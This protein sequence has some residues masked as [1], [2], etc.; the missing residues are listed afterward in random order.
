MLRAGKR[1]PGATS[2]VTGPPRSR[3]SRRLRGIGPKGLGGRVALVAGGAVQRGPRPDHPNSSGPVASGSCRR[4]RTIAGRSLAQASMSC[5][6]NIAA[7]QAARCAALVVQS[8]VC[9]IH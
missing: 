6:S 5:R 2:A 4:R 7:A 1:A 8:Y 9:G 3:G